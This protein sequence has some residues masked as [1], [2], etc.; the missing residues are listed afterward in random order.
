M[1]GQHVRVAWT[2]DVYRSVLTMKTGVN[3]NLKDGVDPEWPSV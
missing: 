2:F 1:W 3:P